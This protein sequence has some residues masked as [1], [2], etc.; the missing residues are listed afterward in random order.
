MN[1]TYIHT[2]PFAKRITLLYSSREAGRVS[3]RVPLGEAVTNQVI[4]RHFFDSHSEVMIE[5]GRWIC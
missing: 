4:G 2:L 3:T 5:G 1:T